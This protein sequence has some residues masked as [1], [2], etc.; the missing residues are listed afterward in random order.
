MSAKAKNSQ[1]ERYYYETEKWIGTMRVAIAKGLDPAMEAH[2]K[3]IMPL[4]ENVLAH[5]VDRHM[6]DVWK[7]NYPLEIWT[8]LDKKNGEDG[9]LLSQLR[10]IREQTV[11]LGNSEARA[12]AT[13]SL[14]WFKFFYDRAENLEIFFIQPKGGILFRDGD[15]RMG[16][17][18]P[19]TRAF[20]LEDES[21]DKLCKLFAE[22]EE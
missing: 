2:I 17:L 11:L 9:G 1:W 16:L 8:V 3:S 4:R 18:M 13:V 20:E 19:F 12:V 5:R 10:V 15:L 22:I 7:E 21:R 14:K 6:V